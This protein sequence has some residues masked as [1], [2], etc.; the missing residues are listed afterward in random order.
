METKICTKCGKTLP[1]DQFNW[2]NKSKGTRRSECKFCHSKY[3]KEKYQEKKQIINNLKQQQCCVKCGDNRPYVL[4][5]HHLDPNIKDMNVSRMLS[6]R[7][8]IN[9]VKQ[10]INKC[11]VLCAN[12]HREFHY[13][14]ISIDEYLAGQYN[15][16]AQG[17][18]P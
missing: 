17:F 1:I 6:N 8:N 4:D 7:S 13:L 9:D 10:E 5:Y 11:I 14:N 15:G 3:M 16:S 18:D 2:R 12:C